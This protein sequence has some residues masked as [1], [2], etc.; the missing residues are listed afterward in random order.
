MHCG[1]NSVHDKLKEV[2]GTSRQVTVDLNVVIKH[3][4][5]DGLF[6]S[7]LLSGLSEQTNPCKATLGR[8]YFPGGQVDTHAGL[9]MIILYY[10]TEHAKPL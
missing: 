2:K 3:V 10:V 8:G 6:N 7:L 5:V 4:S 1:R 9:N